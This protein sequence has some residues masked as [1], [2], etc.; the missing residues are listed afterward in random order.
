MFCEKCGKELREGV[1]FCPGCGAVLEKAEANNQSVQNNQNVPS[2]VSGKLTVY[3]YTEWYAVKPK[4]DILKNGIKIAEVNPDS[5]IEIPITEDC[6]IQFK[7][8]FRTATLQAYAGRNQAVKLSFNR[9]TGELLIN[10]PDQKPLTNTS[11]MVS[12]NSN[13]AMTAGTNYGKSK[14]V[15]GILGI[16]LGGLGLHKFYMGNI[17]MGI[18]YILFCWTYIPAIV[19]L[20]EG[21]IYLTETDEKFNSRCM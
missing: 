7:C 14:N 13:R 5:M 9:I 1:K 19:G 6:T 15:A 10:D 21:I 11:N 12:G 17:K 18:L 3:G 16:L 20:I 4:V 2:G 8:M